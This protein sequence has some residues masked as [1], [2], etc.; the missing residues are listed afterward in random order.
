MPRTRTLAL[1]VAA[2]VLAGSLPAHGQAL[3]ANLKAG[4]RAISPAEAY[5]IVKTLALPE[6]AGRLT[7]HPGYTAAAEWAARKLA[8]WGLKPVS[9]K[10]GYLQPYPS[11]YTV[12]DKAEMTVLL[13]DGPPDPAK[14]QA[15]KEMKL[16]PEKDFLPLLYSASG[17]RTADAVFAGWGIS[18]PELG[19]DDYA[20]LDI[21]GKFVLC[22]RGTPDRDPKWTPYDEHR[23]RMAAARDRGALGVVYIYDEIASNPNGDYLEGFTPAMISLKVMDA[24]L[25]ENGSTAADLRKVLTTYKRPLSFPLR[26]RL[27]LAVSSRHFPQAV[28]YNVVGY[29]EGSDPKLRRECVVIGGHFDHTGAHMGLLF[30][31]ADDN[32]SG[33]ATVMAAGKAA[34]ALARRPKRSIVVALFGGEELGLQGSTW[35]VDHV[36]GPFDRIAGMLNFDMTGEGDG[37]WGAVSPEPPDFKK[38]IETADATVK[39]LRGL[40]VISGV[41][42]R[43]SDFAPFFLKGVPAA[44]LGSNGPHLAYHQTGDTVYRIN[45]DITADA[46]KL[47][48]LAA[49]YWADR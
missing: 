22:F 7:G 25:K 30:P 9:G 12:V 16:A 3:D 23:T 32:A 13:P 15:Y 42:V 1:A 18:A 26:A 44:S 24:L 34:A 41:G 49:Y 31:G 39:V 4:L 46:A 28:G 40:G 6:Y 17:D 38:A 47:A 11:P 45:P 36:P 19:Y 5:D 14:G 37:L 10:D 43:G 29:V 33:S 21:K 35:F 2:L 48:F 8:S 27:R 20:G